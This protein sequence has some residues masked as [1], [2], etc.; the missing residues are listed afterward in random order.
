VLLGIMPLVFVIGGLVCAAI[1]NG[2][3][4]YLNYALG[5]MIAAIVTRL[6]RWLLLYRVRVVRIGMNSLEVRFSSERYA[7][8]FAKLNDLSCRNH[9]SEKRIP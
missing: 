9:R 5:G 8:E 3:K 2:S 6:V 4:D 1:K 7:T